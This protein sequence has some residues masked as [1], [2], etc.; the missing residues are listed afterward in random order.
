MAAQAVTPGPPEIALDVRGNL[1]RW[2][3]LSGS[4]SAA[5]RG[6]VELMPGVSIPLWLPGQ[7]DAR[8]QTVER[9]REAQ[10]EDERV[11]RWQIAGQVRE[12]AWDQALARGRLRVHAAR[13]TAA[14]ELEED[15][16]RRVAAGDL[17]P[18]DLML[19]RAERVAGEAALAN[20]RLEV[21][22]ATS[23]LRQL[24]DAQEVDGLAESPNPAASQAIDAHPVLALADAAVQAAQAVRD[25]SNATRRDPPRVSVAVR[26]E[27]DGFDQPW[28]NSLRLGV[29]IPLDTEAR[30]AP[31]LAAAQVALVDAQV[32]LERTRRALRAEVERAALVVDAARAAVALEA[33]RMDQLESARAALERSFRAG[34]RG[35]PDVLRIRA[36][37]VEAA[38]SLEAA[39]MTLGRAIARLNQS[40]GQLP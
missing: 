39:R 10:A 5:E 4:S 18:V 29:S 27:R 2:A 6:I 33:G 21:D 36:Q 16:A 37:A 23:R 9:E 26:A 11:M 40:R 20:A 25:E 17:A 24:C 19:A 13:H 32:A 15:V 22:L 14:L 31:R 38:M 8:Q 28:R 12:A 1:P 35:L 3:S 30:N 7:R 34:E